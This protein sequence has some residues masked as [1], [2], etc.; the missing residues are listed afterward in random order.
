MVSSL[1][2]SNRSLIL[3]LGILS[4]F[5]PLSTDLYMPALPTIAKEFHSAYV[6]QTMA[7]YFFGLSVGQLLY[8]PVSD[9]IGRKIPLLFGCSLYALASLGCAVA[10]NLE[11]LILFRLLQALGSSTG[12]VTT[13][14]IVRDVFPVQYSARVFSYLF[15]VMGVAPILAPF[16]GGQILLYLSWR[17]VF[18][19]LCGFGL[20]CVSLVVLVLPESHPPELR[21]RS[22]IT[23]SFGEYGRLLFDS[24]FMAFAVP[25]SLMGAGFLTYLSGA[26]MVFI[27][28]FGVSPQNF[29]WI[30]GLNAVGLITSS[31]LNN[32]LLR[33]FSGRRIM[34]GTMLVMAV[35]ALLLVFVATSGFAGMWGLWAMLFVCVG[36]IGFIRPNAQAAA[37]A[38]YPE[39]AGAASSL[40]SGMGSIVGSMASATLGL[41]GAESAVPMATII[42]AAYGLALLVFWCNLLGRTQPKNLSA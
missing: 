1:K 2:I 30:F 14:S 19:I 29:G 23:A 24:R 9:R 38:P 28:L 7:A 36:G 5:G 11:I 40:M 37:M 6:Q 25:N 18:F 10:P 22:P 15:L 34:F 3:T 35:A 12:M 39:R 8:G 21:N 31:Q 4:S 17:V 42:A 20:L 26:A 32:V 27:G 41:L 16:V 33:F 13:V